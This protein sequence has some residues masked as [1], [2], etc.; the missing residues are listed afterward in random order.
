MGKAMRLGCVPVVVV[1]DGDVNDMPFM[2]VLRWK[3]MAVFVKGGVKN[4]TDT[5][6]KRQENM[7]RL[8][9]EGSKHLQWNRPPKPLDAFNTIMYQLWLR[10]H[11]VRY[12]SSIQSN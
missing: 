8:C 12:E 7:K 3:E 5:W 1:T 4:N 9:V 10:R 11:T 2:D 6:K